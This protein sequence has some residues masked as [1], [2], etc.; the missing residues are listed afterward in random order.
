[1]E[2]A[3]RAIFLAL[4]AKGVATG[5]THDLADVILRAMLGAT[6]AAKVSRDLEPID[7]TMGQLKLMIE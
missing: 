2:G 7:A 5:R 3:L 6:M 1:M 4:T